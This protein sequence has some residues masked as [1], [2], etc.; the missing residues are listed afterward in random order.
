MGALSWRARLFRAGVQFRRQLRDLRGY[1]LDPVPVEV[2]L[3]GRKEGEGKRG[4]LINFYIFA[5]P[6]GEVPE[7]SIGPHSKCGERVTVPGVRIPTSPQSERESVPSL[8]E[9]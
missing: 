8:L 3:P 1:L 4:E 2:F 6:I 9:R 5:V 7:W